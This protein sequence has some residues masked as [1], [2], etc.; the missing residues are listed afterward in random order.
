MCVLRAVPEILK[1]TS[2][3]ITIMMQLEPIAV[4]MFRLSAKYDY[5]RR[6]SQP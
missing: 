4:Y 2:P 1:A 6:S 5:L 3:S